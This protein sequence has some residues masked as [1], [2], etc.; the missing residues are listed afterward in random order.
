MS[1]Y[2][3]AKHPI[4]T[5]KVLVA[6]FIDNTIEWKTLNVNVRVDNEYTEDFSEVISNNDLSQIDQFFWKNRNREFSSIKIHTISARSRYS[7]EGTNWSLYINNKYVG[8]LAESPGPREYDRIKMITKNGGL[9]VTDYSKE[10]ESWIIR[11]FNKVD[12][13]ASPDLFTQSNSDSSKFKK[14]ETSS[15]S[16]E[17]LEKAFLKL[18]EKPMDPLRETMERIDRKTNEISSIKDMIQKL[19]MRVRNISMPAPSISTSPQP[20]SNIEMQEKLNKELNDSR[21]KINSLEITLNDTN[22]RLLTAESRIK[23]QIRNKFSQLILQLQLY[24]DESRL[25]FSETKF[26]EE[27]LSLLND[28]EKETQDLALKYIDPLLEQHMHQIYTIKLLLQILDELEWLD[29]R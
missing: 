17:S 11:T 26:T 29:K 25:N 8:H 12:Y 15:N 10:T 20:E 1:Y 21:M 2:V 14:T 24:R 4:E 27:F 22:H 19:E 7:I 3:I 23:D 13:N 6:S 18:L 5:R 9:I 28:K 16:S